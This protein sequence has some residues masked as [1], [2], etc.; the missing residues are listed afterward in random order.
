MVVVKVGILTVDDIVQGL[1]R[2]LK[3]IEPQGKTDKNLKFRRRC[4]I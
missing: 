3:L 1:L 2:R 4:D